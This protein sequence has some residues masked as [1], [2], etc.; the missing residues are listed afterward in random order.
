MSKHRSLHL[1]APDIGSGLRGLVYAVLAS[2]FFN[3]L[4]ATAQVRP[5]DDGTA[6]PVAQLG[7]STG[8]HALSVPARPGVLPQTHRL[9]NGRDVI[10]LTR[11]GWIMRVDT[12]Q[13]R[14][15]AEFKADA[16]FTSAALSVPQGDDTA[17][18][19]AASDAPPALLVFTE[20]LQLIKSLPLAGGATGGRASGVLTILAAPERNSFITALDGLAEMWEIS[21]DPKAPEIGLGWVHDFQ[22]RE[23]QFIRGYLNPK[24]TML[25]CP[26]QAMALSP[27][28]HDVLTLHH[29]ADQA[30]SGA[31]AMF[32]T[33]HLDVRKPTSRVMLPCRLTLESP[34]VWRDADALVASLPHLG[35]AG[36]C[37]LP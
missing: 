28:G 22:Y 3:P 1:L 18:L 34:L 13:N 37:K 29:C 16:A 32:Q 11:G 8:E 36:E 10:L 6:P 20:D 27:S 30:E 26:A 14:V 7:R 23:G 31:V 4:T 24:R 33:T 9:S 2:L 25:P 15:T 21:Y 35:A 5:Q 19:M 17:L 12:R